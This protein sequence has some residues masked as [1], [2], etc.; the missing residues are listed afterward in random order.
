MTEETVMVILIACGAFSA[1][2]ILL[3]IVVSFSRD[4]DHR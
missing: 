4:K 3:A 2:V 1:G